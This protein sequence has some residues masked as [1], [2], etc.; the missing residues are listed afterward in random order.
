[1]IL[2]C[3]LKYVVGIGD[4]LELEIRDIDNLENIIKILPNPDIKIAKFSKDGNLLFCGSSNGSIYIWD[5]S[6]WIILYSFNGN[7]I[8]DKTIC[9]KVLLKID[10][11][12][13]IGTEMRDIINVKVFGNNEPELTSLIISSDSK[14]IAVRFLDT[15]Y[16]WKNYNYHSKFQIPKDVYSIYGAFS[17]DNSYL[18]LYDSTRIF[19]YDLSELKFTKLNIANVVDIFPLKNNNFLIATNFYN[20]L[21]IY[22]FCRVFH[23]LR[24]KYLFKEDVQSF[25]FINENFCIFSSNIFSSGIYLYKMEASFKRIRKIDPSDSYWETYNR[26]FYNLRKIFEYSKD[27]FFKIIVS[28]TFKNELLDP[29]LFITISNFLDKN[30]G[31]IY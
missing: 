31:C 1:M 5:T 10:K 9:D 22:E 27:K 7:P 24:K 29:T 2:D 26:K 20:T 6:N 15:F 12:R 8:C 3:S 4:S 14:Y 30:E 13:Y 19:H 21:N 16:I 23:S 18:L 11:S 25:K 17:L 28:N